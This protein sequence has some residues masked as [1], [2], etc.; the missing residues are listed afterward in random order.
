MVL[1][2]WPDVTLGK[3]RE[4]TF[5]CTRAPHCRGVK[6]DPSSEEEYAAFLKTLVEVPTTP[7]LFKECIAKTFSVEERLQRLEL[8]EEDKAKYEKTW[9]FNIDW[10]CKV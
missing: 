10:D 8:L 7:N 1:P 3:F 5:L 6:G 2:Q 9:Q 4:A